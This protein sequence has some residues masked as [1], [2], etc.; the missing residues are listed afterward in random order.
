MVQPEPCDK[1]D[2]KVSCQEAFRRLGDIEGRSM[3]RSVLTAFVLPLAVFIGVLALAQQLLMK[4]IDSVGL[5][6]AVALLLAI[7][8]S[9]VCVAVARMIGKRRGRR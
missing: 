7:A 6:A 5:R 4:Y 1:C 3:V 2:R 8:A 9:A